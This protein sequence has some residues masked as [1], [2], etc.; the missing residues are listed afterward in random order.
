MTPAI[1]PEYD[2]LL[3]EIQPKPPRSRPVPRW[4]RRKQAKAQ[5]SEPPAT[6]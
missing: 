2:R 5:A 6:A 3:H 1:D 4:Q